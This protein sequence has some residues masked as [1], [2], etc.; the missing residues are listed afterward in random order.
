[1]TQR[2]VLLLLLITDFLGTF[3]SRPLSASARQWRQRQADRN[4]ALVPQGGNHSSPSGAIMGIIQGIALC[5]SHRRRRRRPPRATRT[6]C[7]GICSDLCAPRRTRHQ[8]QIHPRR[9]RR[10]N[11]SSPTRQGNRAPS[12]CRRTGQGTGERINATTRRCSRTGASSVRF[13]SLAMVK[14]SPLNGGCEIAIIRR[15]DHLS[16]LCAKPIEDDLPPDRRRY[17]RLP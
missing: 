13:D 4:R 12:A 16:P 9:H 14:S 3:P 7:G 8:R 1:L 11:G 2:K 5:P 10:R 15:M 6:P 17:V